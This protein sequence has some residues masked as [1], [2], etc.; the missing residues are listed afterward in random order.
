[1]ITSNLFVTGLGLMIIGNYIYMLVEVSDE[2]RQT[3]MEDMQKTNF[4][5]KILPQL[6]FF[7]RF[8]I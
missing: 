5:F 4:A 8:L 3:Y 6:D 2:K 7:L 1:M